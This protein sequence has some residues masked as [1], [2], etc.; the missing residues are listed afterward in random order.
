MFRS[1]QFFIRY[2]WKY[3]KW[4]I[5]EKILAQ[6]T[7]SLTPLALTILP[8]FIIDELMGPQRVER[9]ALLAA[10]L[11]GSV[12]L[13]QALSTF[14]SKDSFSHRCRVEAAFQSNLHAAQA[15]A[16]FGRLE[17]PAFLD[18]RQKAEKF[19]GC[20][21][22]GFGY[23]LDCALDICGQC[24]TLV[25]ISAVVFT[26]N[27]WLILLF[28]AMALLGGLAEMRAKRKAMALYDQVNRSCR[29]WMYYSGLFGDFRYGKEVRLNGIA[30]WLL[31]REKRYMDDSNAAGERQ[32]S[33]YIASGIAGAT[34]NF[35]Q[36]AAAYA[37]LCARVVGGAIGIGDFSMYTAAVTTFGASLR[38]VM[39]SFVEIRA[40][41]LYFDAVDEYLNIPATLRQGAD[42]PVFAETGH[43]VEFRNV[44]FRYPGQSVWALRH[45]DLAIEPGE[46]LSIVGENGAGKTTFV[47]L[48]TRMY[49]PAEGT[50]LLD[51]V[52][53]REIDYDAYMGMFAA[54]FQDFKLFSFSLRDN[55]AFDL[56]R[57]DAEVEDCLRRAGLGDKLDALENGVH[58]HVN[59]EFDE[60]G[61]EPSG[62]EAQKIALAR[63]LCRNAP[64]VILDEPTAA[65]DPRAEYELYQR[66]AGLVEG[67][68]AL[69][70]SHRLSSAR[71][72][73]RIAVFAGGE[74][75][76]Y[77][78]HEELCALKGI[79]AELYAMQA[80]FYA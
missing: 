80:Q 40:Y 75:A 12:F 37:Y 51:G 46:T 59:R 3:D 21:Y 18:L 76:E 13:M 57:T 45:V 53:I 78:T 50:I 1:L 8:K 65:L 48:L 9:L 32:N 74:L 26:L 38:R 77:G 66:F 10:L 44:G 22:H 49:D 4:Y 6:L 43:R 41:D 69:F 19:L 28:A 17:D 16:D 67:K 33:Y 39:D 25:G 72:C 62:G 15:R 27:G 24:I 55:V 2:G 61:F 29:G 63:A 20:D 23:L 71:F 68:S 34:C 60:H 70:I 52:D 35:V 47:K 5:I 31:A 79:Y 11:T 56:E 30:D 14:L 54:V 64:F 42:K 36:Q 58:T 7:G 73:D